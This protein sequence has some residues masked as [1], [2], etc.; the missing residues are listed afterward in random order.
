MFFKLA[1]YRFI[2][3]YNMLISSITAIGIG[4]TVYCFQLLEI[5]HYTFC[6]N[7]QN[8]IFFYG[9]KVYRLLMLKVT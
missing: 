5:L 2:E 7:Q 1:K 3:N 8:E 9:I 6:D 4:G